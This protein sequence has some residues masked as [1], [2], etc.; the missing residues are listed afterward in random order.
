MCCASS[1]V[2]AGSATGAVAHI[3]AGKPPVGAEL[4][5]RRHDDAVAFGRHVLLHEHGIGAGRHRRAGENADRLARLERAVGTRAGGDAAG[6]RQPGFAVGIQIGVA[7]GI[8]IDRGIIER[9]QI[10]RRRHVAAR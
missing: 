5:A 3:L 8:A 4:Q 9:R 6:D 2:P 1:T 10:D 7:H